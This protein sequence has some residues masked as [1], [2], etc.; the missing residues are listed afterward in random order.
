MTPG[1]KTGT[2]VPTT[3]LRHPSGRAALVAAVVL[4]TSAMASVLMGATGAGAADSLGTA[5]GGS[6][7]SVGHSGWFWGD[8]QPQGN[9]LNGIDFAGSRGYAAG[10]FGTLLRTDDGGATWDGLP[11]GITARLVNVRVVNASTV[12]IGGDCALRRSDDGGQTFTRLPWTASDQNCPSSIASF[13]FP[14][15]SVGYLMTRDGSI[16]R[17][18]DGGATFARK[19]SIPGTPSAGGSRSPTDIFFT[20]LNAGVVTTTQGG[21]GKIF[22]TTDGGNSW[23]EVASAPRGPAATTNGLHGLDFAGGVG[24]AVGSGQTLLRST[25]SGAT[26]SPKG[27]VG[28]SGFPDLESIGCASATTCLMTEA[29]GGQL[30]RTTDGGDHGKLV[31]P[32]TEKIFAAGFASATRAVAVGDDGATVVSNNAG[33]TWTPVGGSLAGSGFDRL[34]ATN[35]QLAEAGGNNGT[36][37]RTIDGGSNWFTVGVPTTGAVRDASFPSQ[38]TG[39]AL[40]SEGGAFRTTN[41]GTTWSIL[42]TGASKDPRALLAVNASRVL[43]VGPQGLRLSTNGGSSFKT[44]KSKAVRGKSLDDVDVASGALVAVGERALAVSKD[45]GGHWKK[46]KRPKDQELVDADFLGASK[47]YVL[48]TTGAVF[49]TSNGGEKWRVLKAVGTDNGYGIS[50]SSAQHGY[51]AVSRL[52]NQRFGFVLRTRNGGKTWQPQL[53]APSPVEV[54][55]ADSTG[56]AITPYEDGFFATTTG[57]QAGTSS[58]LTLDVSKGKS[59]KRT[60]RTKVIGRLSPPEGGEQIVVAN[61]KAGNPRWHD[62]TLTAATNGKFTAKFKVRK[63]LFVVAQWNGDDERAGA[64]SKVLVLKPPR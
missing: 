6:G 37:A 33:R 38:G 26:W 47:G 31:T 50:F 22:R 52:G 35:S 14:S 4:A 61:R 13:Y 51:L 60:K 2:K 55:D 25:D 16:L 5:T 48:T 29:D 3:G 27:L 23:T 9:A 44:V 1:V 11:T 58:K 34:R 18:D 24:Y 49:K 32:S 54:W 30:V 59:S 7:V 20:G 53:I 62:E 43:L 17:T 41:G 28:V 10:D 42:D 45:N 40:D 46:L 57:G 56:Y 12:V 64:G 36:L 21:D 19:T 15:A 63:K 8:P 39:F